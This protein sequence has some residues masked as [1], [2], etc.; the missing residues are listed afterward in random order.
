MK[1]VILL[2]L[3]MYLMGCSPTN[4][5]TMSVIEPAPVDLPP[6]MERI[7]IINRS[8]S[9]EKDQVL[10]KID[11][12]LS[13]EGKNLDKDGASES[14][15]GL[16]EELKKND[17]F[18]KVAMLESEKL[19]NPEFGVFPSPVSWDRITEICKENQLDGLF[20]L[21]FYDTDSKFKYDA[22]KVTLEGPLGVEIPA[23]EHYARATTVI[24]TGWRIYDNTGRNIIDEY[25]ITESVTLDG[26]G[27]NPTKAAAAITGRKEA[28]QQI[29]NEI[30]RS[31]ALGIVPYQTR[32]KRDY[33]VKGNENFKAAKRRAQTGNWDGAAEI[34]MQETKNS[35]PK[36][37]GQAFYNMAIIHE[38][39]GEM[40]QAIEWARK[41]YEDFGTKLAL[42]Y[43]NILKDRKARIQILDRQQQQ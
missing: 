8:E 42:R 18:E 35:D 32:V 1:K 28:V 21:E 41:S 10:E 40:D 27:V 23:L 30:G 19:E 24:K 29:S 7:G 3:T 22:E 26:R 12:V 25:V 9:A 4:T 37:A 39:E 36:I 2:F 5:L 43:L 16:N 31:Y 34:W 33:Y 6:S 11:Q 15:T 14:I 13:V 17:R 20:S 38:I